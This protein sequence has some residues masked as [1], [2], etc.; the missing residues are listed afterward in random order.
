MS[1]EHDPL[2]GASGDPIVSYAPVLTHWEALAVPGSHSYR[3]ASSQYADYTTQDLRLLRPYESRL[4]QP[5]LHL[6]CLEMMEGHVH[7]WSDQRPREGMQASHGQLEWTRHMLI[8]ESEVLTRAG[9]YDAVF[10]SLFDY[11]PCTSLLRAFME[12]WN[13]PTNTLFVGDRE[14]TITLWELRQLVGLPISGA[15]YDEYI[16][17]NE[18]WSGL[19][20]PLEAVFRIYQELCSS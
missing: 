15:P 7:P 2:P 8:Y 3:R 11:R 10:L 4:D 6:S 1:L 16:P 12:R 17:R 20:G 5:T 9:I 14:M 13:F 19:S 18:D